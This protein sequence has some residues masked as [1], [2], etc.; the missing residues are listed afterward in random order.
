VVPGSRNL[1]RREH[2]GK[3]AAEEQEA[4][5]GR[6]RSIHGSTGLPRMEEIATALLIERDDL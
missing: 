6:A 5:K 3:R 4:P 2:Q 1:E